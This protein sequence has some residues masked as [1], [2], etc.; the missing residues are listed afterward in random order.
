MILLSEI[1]DS[2]AFGRDGGTVDATD[3]KS[4]GAMLRAGSNPAPGTKLSPPPSSEAGFFHKFTLKNISLMVLLRAGHQ[5]GP[6]LVR[7]CRGFA[8]RYDLAAFHRRHAAVL[9]LSA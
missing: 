7:I 8:E 6:I 2:A 5:H 1:I 3:L 9:E 4:V